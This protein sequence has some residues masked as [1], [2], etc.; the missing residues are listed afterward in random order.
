MNIFQPFPLVLGAGLLG[1]CGVAMAAV[2]AHGGGDARLAGLAAE[3]ALVHAPALL[4]LAGLPA[5][6]IRFRALAGLLV[7]TGVVLFSGDLALRFFRDARL[8]EGAAPTGGTL[9]IVGW[10]V[11]GAGVVAA[12]IRP[13][14]KGER[15]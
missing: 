2:A 13:V 5:T 8:F 4:A 9:L 11:L 6:A 3:I 7:F 14:D 10:L 1:A 15:T 12:R